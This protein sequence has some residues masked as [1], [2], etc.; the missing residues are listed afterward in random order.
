M[1]SPPDPSMSTFLMFLISKMCGS[2]RA[3]LGAW[4]LTAWIVVGLGWVETRVRRSENGNKEA[5]S[6]RVVYIVVLGCPTILLSVEQ[7]RVRPFPQE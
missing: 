7:K 5:T 2:S 3:S 1:L 6:C 4:P